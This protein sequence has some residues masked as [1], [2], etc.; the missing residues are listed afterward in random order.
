MK[1]LASLGIIGF[2]I[3]LVVAVACVIVYI[4]GIIFG[5]AH[6]ILLGIVSIIPFVGFFE[7]L[8]HLLGAI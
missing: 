7:G 3:W 2:L 8:L 6:S 1:A 5:F 4:N